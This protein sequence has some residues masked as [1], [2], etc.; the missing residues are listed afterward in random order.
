ML[1][2]NMSFME[3]VSSDLIP[4]FIIANGEIKY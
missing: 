2:T 3:T 1:R 4:Y